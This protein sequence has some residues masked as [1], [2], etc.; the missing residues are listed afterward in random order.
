MDITPLQNHEVDLVWPRVKEY[1]AMA[2]EYTYGRFTANDI[3][4]RLKNSPTQQL[5]IAHEGEEVYGFVITQPLDYPQLRALVMHFTAGKELD[6]WK[7]P[8]L[9]QM[10]EYAVNNG[11]DLIESLGR[12]GWAKVFKDDGYKKLYTWYQLPVGDDK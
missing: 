7:E 3:R 4:S 9:A 1:F 12:E 2:A 11:C 8:M 10:K 5:W 6:K